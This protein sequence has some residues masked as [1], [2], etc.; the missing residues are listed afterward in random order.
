[1]SGQVNFKCTSTRRP[2]NMRFTLIS[3]V[4]ALASTVAASDLLHLGRLIPP[5]EETGGLALLQVAATSNSTANITGSAYFTQLL[6]H[7]DP[8]KGTFQQRY[9]W[10]AANWAGPGSPVCDYGEDLDRPLLICNRLS[11]SLLVKSLQQGILDTSPISLS[12]DSTHKRSKVLW[13]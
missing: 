12:L 4:S 6:D 2:F 10:N 8:R 11:C 1:M 7:N 5:V 3:A 9:W 13:L